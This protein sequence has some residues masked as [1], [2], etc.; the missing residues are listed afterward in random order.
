MQNMYNVFLATGCFIWWKGH[1]NVLYFSWNRTA[2]PLR[3]ISSFI[4]Q[5]HTPPTINLGKGMRFLFKWL[6]HYRQTESTDCFQHQ[7][8]LPKS[9]NRN[10]KTQSYI[11][12]YSF[13]KFKVQLKYENL[14]KYQI[15]LL[16]D[17]QAL[18]SQQKTS[19]TLPDWAKYPFI[20]VSCALLPDTAAHSWWVSARG[21]N[22][23]SSGQD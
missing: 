1:S 14:K 6:Q 16:C 20:C 7:I 12:C 10:N 13:Y 19:L 22:S 15:Q 23:G 21:V 11:C 17:G 2:S 5:H 8:T 3:F 9:E 4:M 18:K